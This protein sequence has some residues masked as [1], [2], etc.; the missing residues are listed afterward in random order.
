M[1]HE[2]IVVVGDNFVPEEI[3]HAAGLATVRLAN[4][5]DRDLDQSAYFPSQSCA[6]CRSAEKVV[7]QAH[8]RFAGAVM[9]SSCTAMETLYEVFLRKSE[10]AFVHLLD[11]PKAQSALSGDAYR[12]R[13]A[14]FVK[15]LEA[16][17]GEKIESKSLE[18]AIQLNNRLRLALTKAKTCRSIALK[19]YPVSLASLG[20]AIEAVERTEV[21]S[22]NGSPRILVTGSRLREDVVFQAIE[23]EGGYAVASLTDDGH[24][25]NQIRVA[26]QSNDVLLAIAE[27]YLNENEFKR[28]ITGLPDIDKLQNLISSE[29]IN[30]IVSLSYPFC[31]KTGYDNAWLR[32]HGEELRVPILFYQVED[33]NSASAG[34]RNRLGAFIEIL[35]DKSER[36]H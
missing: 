7:T 3:L 2:P 1:T 31:A 27:G 13:L 35:Q 11:I 34:L 26:E 30:G 22:P 4:V 21:R 29:N 20:D 25:Y 33:V 24:S 23:D 28:T 16:W 17:R 8:R 5:I 14:H 6:F 12:H 18:K 32:K 15:V 36:G 10:L 19:D 9:T